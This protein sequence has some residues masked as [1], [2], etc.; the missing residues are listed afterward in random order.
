MRR[1]RSKNVVHMEKDLQVLISKGKAQGY[2]T[3][4]EVNTYLPNEDVHP[5]KVDN[6]LA[7]L[8]SAG[9]ELCDTPPKPKETTPPSSE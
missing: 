9:I 2:L 6:L 3:Y 1:R 7:A 8:D 4:D 5:E